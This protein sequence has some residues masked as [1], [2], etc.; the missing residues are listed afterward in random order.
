MSKLN[1]LEK[2]LLVELRGIA[3]SYKSGEEAGNY[4]PIEPSVVAYTELLKQALRSLEKKGLISVKGSYDKGWI[5]EIRIK[6]LDME[7][8]ENE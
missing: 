1:Q 6:E 4:V 7:L 5:L 8:R 3:Y 2:Y